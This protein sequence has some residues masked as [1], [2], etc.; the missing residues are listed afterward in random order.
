MFKN[1]IFESKQYALMC[2]KKKSSDYFDSVRLAMDRRGHV[3]QYE[4]RVVSITVNGSLEVVSVTFLY[5]GNH[6]SRQTN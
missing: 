6:S 3:T 4:E 5:L 2:F 1:G